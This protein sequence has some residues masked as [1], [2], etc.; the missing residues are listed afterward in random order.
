MSE[1]ARHALVT[2]GSAGIGHAICAQLLGRSYEVVNLDLQPPERP[3][4]KLHSIEVNLSDR[5]A[6][7]EALAEVSRRFAITTVVHN[8]GAMR[9]APLAELRMEDFDALVELHLGSAVQLVQ[10]ALPA[11]REAR[12]GRI[13][14]LA[15]RAVLGLASRTA[16]STTKA[17]LLGMAR[18]WA[19]ELGPEG[20]TAN[21]IAP[22]PIRTEM[23]YEVIEAGSERER[24]MASS[25]PVRRIG[26]PD[27]V[28]R[29]VA[30][31]TDPA[32]SF[33]TG[34]ALYVCGGTSIGSL[35]L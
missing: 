21:V 9:P 1:P 28:A 6:T 22:G 13:V 14:L 27:D 35:T 25:I 4:P 30:F 16:Y 24:Q 11:M 29:A 32:N 33:V 31:F 34:Q 18:T 2:G 17:G 20:I 19:L 7:R 15:S 23:F 10:A 3:H 12:F 8:A 26:E 5:A